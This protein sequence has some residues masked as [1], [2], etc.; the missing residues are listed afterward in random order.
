M[1]E[2]S[3]P[4]EQAMSGE[5]CMATAACLYPGRLL[6]ITSGPLQGTEAIGVS[7][8]DSRRLIVTFPCFG[9]G[10]FVEVDAAQVEHI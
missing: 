1:V 9:K 10:V 5:E 8:K 7:L 6:R 2:D 4:G 3:Q